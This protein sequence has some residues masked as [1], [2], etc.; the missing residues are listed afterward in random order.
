MKS[1]SFW[2]YIIFCVII[3]TFI[4]VDC[5]KPSKLELLEFLL[6]TKHHLNI[7]KK[8][9]EKPILQF[10]GLV[11]DIVDPIVT[12]AELLLVLER[13]RR[14]FENPTKDNVL[15]FSG[16]NKIEINHFKK[17]HLNHHLKQEYLDLK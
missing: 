3:H 2:F 15:V 11:N 16:K 10:I 4:P 5:Q 6:N 17:S 8:I 12:A 7:L 1:N 9:R 14:E 13:K